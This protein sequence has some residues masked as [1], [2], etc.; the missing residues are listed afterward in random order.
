MRKVNNIV[1]RFDIE[2]ENMT[3]LY[4]KTLLTKCN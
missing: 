3:E 4:M 1:I 2:G